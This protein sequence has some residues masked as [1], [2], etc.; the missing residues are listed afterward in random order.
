MATCNEGPA[1][2]HVYQ[3]DGVSPPPWHW[4]ALVL[5]GLGT[6]WEGTW[7]STAPGRGGRSHRAMEIQAGV[8]VAFLGKF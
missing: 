6:T 3:T 2:S 8:S 1:S 4:S 7:A 5:T